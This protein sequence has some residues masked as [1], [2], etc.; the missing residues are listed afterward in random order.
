MELSGGPLLLP[1]AA[2]TH[3]WEDWLAGVGQL[4]NNSLHASLAAYYGRL[5][6]CLALMP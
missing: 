3:A 6:I 4:A 2:Q 5:T 1:A